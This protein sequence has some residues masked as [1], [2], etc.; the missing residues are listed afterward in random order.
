MAVWTS[1]AMP[2]PISAVTEASGVFTSNPFPTV[3][4]RAPCMCLQKRSCPLAVRSRLS[5]A[6]P[7]FRSQTAFLVTWSA[8]PSLWT[9]GCAGPLVT[10][11]HSSPSDLPRSLSVST[12]RAEA[13]AHISFNCSAICDSMRTQGSEGYR[14][15]RCVWRCLSSGLFESLYPVY[16]ALALSCSTCTSIHPPSAE[17]SDK[18]FS[19]PQGPKIKKRGVGQSAV[20]Q[21]ALFLPCLGTQLRPAWASQAMDPWL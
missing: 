10:P 21:E 20:E 8:P 11:P 2:A 12:A 14:G 17:L 4:S 3:F 6:G 16:R 19:R 18:P 15:R 5:L 7:I 9:L 1:V 13:S